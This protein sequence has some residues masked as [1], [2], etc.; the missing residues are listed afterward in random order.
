MLEPGKRYW[1]NVCGI[2][3]EAIFTGRYDKRNGNAILQG[4]SGLWSIP[5]EELTL[6]T[7]KRKERKI[8][9]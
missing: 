9:G 2:R 6:S 3:R 8:H 1:W 7:G 5:E 4:R